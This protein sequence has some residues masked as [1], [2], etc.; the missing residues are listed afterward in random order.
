VYLWLRLSQYVLIYP[1]KTRLTLPPKALGDYLLG[2]FLGVLAQQA[3]S[4]LR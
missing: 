1:L 4:L 3:S 2:N